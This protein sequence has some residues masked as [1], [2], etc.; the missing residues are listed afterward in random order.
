MQLAFLCLLVLALAEPFFSSEASGSR[1][2][3]LVI[4]NSASMNA[5]DGSPTRLD[6]AKEQG[7]RIIDGLGAGDEMAIVA[8]GTQPQVVCGLTG[9][10]R[11][12][13]TA[14]D[15]V[16]ATDGPTRVADAVALAR[17]LLAGHEGSKV[18]VLTDGCFDGALK[19]AQAPDVQVAPVGHRTGNVGIT[20]FQVRRSLLDPIGYEILVEVVNCSD[21]PVECRLEM[22]LNGDVVDVV[23]L[24]LAADGRWAQVFEKTSADGGRLIARINRP[25]ALM[26]DNEA[27]ALLPKRE[28]Q[29]VTLVTDGDMFL[30]KVF[31]ANPLVRLSVTKDL[32]KAGRR[33]GYGLPSKGADDAAAGSRPGH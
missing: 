22:E 33:R 5:T 10:L 17:R 31:E 20:R 2:L 6:E 13:R 28:Y 16:P 15:A 23:P 3:V 9:H 8:A 21:E 32:S 1:R 27:C 12:L 24:K 18:V 4:D 11:T 7:R 26:A 30:E 14:L 29:P 25:D 19:L